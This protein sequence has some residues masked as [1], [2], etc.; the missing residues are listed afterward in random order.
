MPFDRCVPLIVESKITYGEMSP[1][2]SHKETQ[3]RTTPPVQEQDT[4]PLDLPLRKRTTGT[5]EHSLQNNQ[6]K[7]TSP[8]KKSTSFLRTSS[9]SRLEEPVKNSCENSL[10]NSIDFK[11]SN[12]KLKREDA[13]ES[14]LR[15]SCSSYS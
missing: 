14:L 2:L 8:L 1:R 12:Y 10:N 6:S 3:E 5:T 13:S 15:L 4:P 7:I 9:K 11:F